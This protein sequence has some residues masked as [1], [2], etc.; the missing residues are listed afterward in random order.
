[1]VTDLVITQIVDRAQLDALVPE[2]E[3]LLEQTDVASPFL[4]PGWQLAW[5]DTYGKS[6]QPFVLVARSRGFGDGATC[7]P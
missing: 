4:T 3:A 2:W 7:W 6:H 5:L 1:M